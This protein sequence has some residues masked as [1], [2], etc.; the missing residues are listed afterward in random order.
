MLQDGHTAVGQKTQMGTDETT[1]RIDIIFWPCVRRMVCFGCRP[2][3]AKGNRRSETPAPLQRLPYGGSNYAS[4]KVA[5]G[6][7]GRGC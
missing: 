1:I 3:T 2:G 7:D 4:E 5:R 6:V